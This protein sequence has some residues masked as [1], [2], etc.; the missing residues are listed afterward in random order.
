MSLVECTPPISLIFEDK[1]RQIETLEVQQC[2]E[3][4]KGNSVILLF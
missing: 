2:E 3:Y 4:L 1:H